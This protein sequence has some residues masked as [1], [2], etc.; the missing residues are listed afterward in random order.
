MM[1]LNT[2]IFFKNNKEKKQRIAGGRKEEIT[3][4][5]NSSLE[6]LKNMTRKIN[7]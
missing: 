6:Y 3:I 1:Q 4:F 5:T 2:I 7:I